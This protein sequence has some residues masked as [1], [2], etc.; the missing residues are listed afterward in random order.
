MPSTYALGLIAGLLASASP[1]VTWRDG[2]P[3]DTGGVRQQ[4]RRP[5]AVSV[6]PGGAY[7]PIVHVGPV[8][9]GGDME[10]AA[11][12]GLPI[13]MRV[14]V[15]LWKDR[16]FDQLVDTL[17]W[18]TVIVYEPI[19]EQFFVR[20]L[21]SP[22]GARRFGSFAAARQSIES[23][24]PLTMRPG[25]EGRFYYT[26]SLQIETLQVSDLDE[27]ERWLQGELQ[28][29]VTGE[30][31]VPGAIGQGA[32]RLML[33]LLDLPARRYEARTERFRVSASQG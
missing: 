32:K 28:P 24:Y 6:D 19:G 17:S 9:S 22:R 12:S 33:R 5:L 13:R 29:A 14:R 31:S 11:V 20:S 30:R 16:L 25:D 26:V 2:L 7:R 23:D 15:E 27:L 21:P 4:E 8:L 3:A 10:Q 18:S 1:A